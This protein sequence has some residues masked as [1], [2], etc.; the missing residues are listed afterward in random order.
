M[1][2]YIY[3]MILLSLVVLQGCTDVAVTGA[4]VVYNRRSLQKNFGDQYITMKA[5]QGLYIKTD[6]FQNAHISIATYNRE[7]LLAGQAPEPWQKAKATEIVSKIPDVKRVYNLV[8]LDSPSSTLTRL[9]DSWITAKVKAKLIAS[10]DLDAT[11]IKVVTENGTVYLMGILHPEEAQAAT[12]LASETEGVEKVVK[13]F[14][15]LKITKQLEGGLG[16]SVTHPLS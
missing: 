12:D 10:E 14:S 7:V 13:I 15:Y 16:D 1:R 5:Y 9:S 3:G 4:Q 11:K 6:E 2:K 8:S